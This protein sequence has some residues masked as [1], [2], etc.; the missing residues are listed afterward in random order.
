MVKDALGCIQIAKVA[1][2]GKVGGFFKPKKEDF[3]IGN[4]V[5]L[6]SSISCMC[7]VTFTRGLRFEFV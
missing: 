7:N 1:P 4:R 5:N 6:L 3:F 2:S